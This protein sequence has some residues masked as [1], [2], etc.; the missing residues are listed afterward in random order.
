MT[1]KE[2]IV[3]KIVRQK[4]SSYAAI[5]GKSKIDALYEALDL[6]FLVIQRKMVLAKTYYIPVCESKTNISKPIYKYKIVIKIVRQKLSSYARIREKSKIDALYEALDLA[7]LVIHKKV[8]LATTYNGKNML[9]LP[10]CE[11]KTNASN[12]PMPVYKYKEKEERDNAYKRQYHQ[13]HKK[14]LNVIRAIRRR[15]AKAAEQA[16]KQAAEQAAK[17]AA[18]QAAPLL[19]VS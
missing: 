13:K 10:V 16:A 17:Q 6:A 18:E 7:F 9:D 11:S 14:R 8:V 12:L 1:K 5:R 19:K 3:I 4:L 2:K 15:A